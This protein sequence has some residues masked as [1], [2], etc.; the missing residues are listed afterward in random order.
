[1][2]IGIGHKASL[3]SNS[4]AIGSKGNAVQRPNFFQ[5]RYKGFNAKGS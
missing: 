5:Q 2:R 3:A 4:T 1:M